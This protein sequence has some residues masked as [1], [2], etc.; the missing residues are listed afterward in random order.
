[1]KFICERSEI[2]AALSGVGKAIVSTTNLSVLEGVHIV[3]YADEI[4]LTGY[5]LEMAIISRIK[6]NI[7]ERGEAV[8]SAKLL[9][10]I[11]RK[12]DSDE[13]E[14]EINDDL[15]VTIKGGNAV[16][17][18]TG[19]P[20]QDYPELPETNVE[21]HMNILAQ[22]LKEMVGMT[23]YAVAQNDQ[24]PVHTGIKFFLDFNELTLVSVDGYRLAVAKKKLLNT[25]ERSFV[26]PAR[27]LNEVCQLLGNSDAEIEI[28]TARRY[29]VFTM[30]KYTVLTRL[31]EGEFIDYKRSIPE[32]YKTRVLVNVDQL[33][34]CIERALLLI[35]DRFKS[36]LR[37]KMESGH[38]SIVCK[39][40]LG[41]SYDELNFDQEGDDIEIGFNAR[42]L[43]DA[44][45]NSGSDE[46]WFELN[47]PT[48]PM[49]VLPKEGDSFL[50]LVLPVRIRTE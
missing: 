11:V 17:N 28:S 25:E 49:K 21:N 46:V 12:I 36:P 23:I 14:F 13:I 33:E 31:L 42:Y 29:A 9:T 2:N 30:E 3:A 44:L 10:D 27:T 41:N 19:L 43:L 15:A 6:A 38:I 18:I 16:F 32:G 7:I 20:A 1:M 45:K 39:T 24:K 5:D 50:F 48:A 22:D 37:I 34:D 4:E 26:V 35:T 8:V 47:G 40:S